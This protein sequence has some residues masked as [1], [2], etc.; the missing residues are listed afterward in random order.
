MKRLV[1]L[2]KSTMSFGI[3]TTSELEFIKSNN[4]MLTEDKLVSYYDSKEMAIYGGIYYAL[5][6]DNIE[7]YVVEAFGFKDVDKKESNQ[8]DVL[9]FVITKLTNNGETTNERY[10]EEAANVDI[11]HPQNINLHANGEGLIQIP[12][13]KTFSEAQ[14][15]LAKTTFDESDVYK[16]G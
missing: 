5:K 13:A 4:N 12:N 7:Y 6:N 1:A 9:A 15:Q 11:K 16:V 14:E 2:S 8:K 10:Y 3:D